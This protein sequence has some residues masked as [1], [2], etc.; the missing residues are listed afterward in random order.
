MEKALWNNSW[1]FWKESNAFSLFQSIPA[2]AKTV[3]LPHDA[4]FLEHQDAN[5]VSEGKQG[6]LPGGTY[7]KT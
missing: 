7:A 5:C 6:F 1:T 4:M 3:D 2:D